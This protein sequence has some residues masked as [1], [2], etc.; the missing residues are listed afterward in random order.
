MVTNN[1]NNNTL[2]KSQKKK[3]D[4]M[5]KKRKRN[6]KTLELTKKRKINQAKSEHESTLEKKLSESTSFAHRL[7]QETHSMD[8]FQVMNQQIREIQV[9]HSKKALE[10]SND[11]EYLAEREEMA[12]LKDDESF[13][14]PNAQNIDPSRLVTTESQLLNILDRVLVSNDE[15]QRS[16]ASSSKKKLIGAS[17]Y[18]KN[19]HNTQDK[20]SVQ[21]GK[22][23]WTRK[24]AIHCDYVR[25]GEYGYEERLAQV[26]LVN[27][28]N[29]CVYLQRIA[30]KGEHITDYRTEETGLSA[31]SFLSSSSSSSSSSSGG[32]GGGASSSNGSSGSSSGSGANVVGSTTLKSLEQVRAELLEKLS[33]VDGGGK[34]V[35]VHKKKILVGHQLT[36]FVSDL[37][38]KYNV[39]F[40]RDI[41]RYS[42]IYKCAL[43]RTLDVT[44]VV[45]APSSS[46]SLSSSNSSDRPTEAASSSI[47]D[48]L[49]V[50]SLSVMAAK[51]V[52][53][54]QDALAAEPV[55]KAQCVMRIYKMFEKEYEA[56][57]AKN[58]LMQQ[59]AAPESDGAL[60]G[61]GVKRR[62]KVQKTEQNKK[63]KVGEVKHRVNVRKQLDNTIDA[64]LQQM[65]GS[66]W[67]RLEFTTSVPT[68][69][70]LFVCQ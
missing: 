29:E 59:V 10:R 70:R 25:V 23:L 6:Q 52:G 46:S 38:G 21:S 31:S 18:D 11:A 41:A 55:L 62:E 14:E 19:M 4:F 68:F 1:N 36:K 2:S 15:K 69:L 66:T 7:A 32:G 3:Q 30:L 65:K 27:E 40:Q 43:P 61:A 22:K 47:P 39:Q 57:Y 12:Q 34:T 67:G 51:F 60:S 45:T 26:C 17:S 56:F 64:L 49:P 35:N 50:E 37:F 16:K 48:E 63:E 58:A 24:M 44:S 20:K 42:P 53:V 5:K 13:I 28:L 8:K 54:S 33:H 9:L